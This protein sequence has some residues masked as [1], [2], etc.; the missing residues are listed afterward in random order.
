MSIPDRGRVVSPRDDGGT[1]DA[2]FTGGGELGALCR[3]F[4]WGSTPLGP[5]DA[6]SHS[7]RTT[8]ATVINSR[9]PMFLW[10][11]PELIQIYND[12]YR[13]SLGVGGRH[14]RAL[15]MG[16]R[17]FWTDIWEIIGPQIEGVMSAGEATWHEDQLVAIERND[18]IEEVYWTYGYS[19]VR[20]DDG[21]IG[22][23]LVV[24]QETTSRVI[25]ERRLR[26]LHRLAAAQPRGSLEDVARQ[27]MSTL[28]GDRLDIPFALLYTASDATV[29]GVTAAAATSAA[30]SI[31]DI[32][33]ADNPLTGASFPGHAL[34]HA[35]GEVGLLAP[36]R[37]P[38][39]QDLATG[40][41]LLVDV[42]GWP[43]LEGVGP[44]PETPVSAVVL[45]VLATGHDR[46][47][48]V[49]VAGL[50]ARLGW[51]DEYREFFLGAAN[52]VGAHL[53]ARQL[54]DERDRRDRELE[55]ERARLAYVFHH[56]PA[57][58]AILKGPTHTFELV[59]DAYYQLVGHRDILGRPVLE[60]LPEV[61]N[62]GFVELLDGVLATGEPFIGRE[63]PIALS[64]TPGESPQE[65]YVDLV[66]LPLEDADGTRSGIIAH[67]ADVTDHVRA[68]AEVERLF[69]ES[70]VAR[71]EAEQASRAK[72][73]FLANMS[74]ELRTPING[75]L[76]YTDLLELGLHGE[77]T[78][79]QQS[80]VDRIRASSRH[81]IALVNEILDLSKIEAGG[82]SVASRPVPVGDTIRE[83]LEMTTPLADAK[84]IQVTYGD[85]C[86]NDAMYQGDQDRVRQILANL[87]SNAVKFTRPGGRVA[88]RCS[89]VD[90]APADLELAVP[91]SRPALVLEVEDTGIGIDAPE[92][93][94]IFEPFVQVDDS[95]TR[96]ADGTGLGLTISRN[97]ARMM[98]GD[99]T[100]RSQPGKGSTFTLWLP[101]PVGPDDA[102]DARDGARD[103]ARED[104]GDTAQGAH[105]E[106]GSHD[107]G[108]DAPDRADI[109]DAA[110]SPAGP[111]ASPLQPR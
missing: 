29:A 32:T 75:V 50:S 74:H 52:H 55:V 64:R 44:W 51:S 72:G 71:Q 89:A 62:Q 21:S 34:L 3:E 99:L 23:T 88:V 85:G 15:G 10:W 31:A 65:R 22:G 14:P 9:H 63:V 95:N 57:F 20:D 17:E 102:D 78:D 33:A 107:A 4:D 36:D 77:L 98:D 53:A 56:A 28:V 39:D 7:L 69:Q 24:C 1:A 101:M 94:R 38:L 91:G 93:A 87:L 80:F 41:P 106:A 111:G 66:Y 5:V 18:R 47:L 6:W 67:G 45:P 70:E 82:M 97:L 16:A 83:A 108:R 13:P 76:G 109:A 61:A 25:A 27:V 30:A 84:G 58:L 60:A 12:G 42:R 46:P 19:P 110:G 2:V 54:R 86:E 40:D 26:T 37:W 92:L 35:E 68:R 48:G 43:E 81:L 104:A 11:G 105:R 90:Q 73:Q 8:A 103:N 100:V 59:N 79:G 49:L 96:E